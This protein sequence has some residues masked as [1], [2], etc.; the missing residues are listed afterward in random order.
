M[1][2]SPAPTPRAIRPTRSASVPDETPILVQ[3]NGAVQVVGGTLLGLGVL[4]R[5]A[6]L[7]LAA[8]LV[9]TTLAG[10][11]FWEEADPSPRP[12]LRNR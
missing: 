3:V 11:R 6:A 8:S 2:S 1:T 12:D 7:A 9:P 4:T 10:H 5:L